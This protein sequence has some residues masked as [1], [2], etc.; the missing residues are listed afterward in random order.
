MH[1][2]TN[3]KAVEVNLVSHLAQYPCPPVV[4]RR[5]AWPHPSPAPPFSSLPAR[6]SEL[7]ALFV[8]PEM[9]IK[10]GAFVDGVIRRLLIAA[11]RH[12]DNAARNSNTR[13]KAAV[14]NACLALITECHWPVWSA[15]GCGDGSDGKWTAC[16]SSQPRAAAT[17]GSAAGRAE[18][19]PGRAAAL[20]VLVRLGCG[21]WLFVYAGERTVQ[22]V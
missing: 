17:L 11:H 21:G 1:L 15:I 5:A 16:E 12:T 2:S 14:H 3:G 4:T 19:V 6:R 9:I 22:Y 18:C 8:L 20:S 13:S 10:C 7:R